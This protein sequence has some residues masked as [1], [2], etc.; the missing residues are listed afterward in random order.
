MDFLTSLEQMPFSVWVREGGSIWGYPTI[1]CL[2]TMGMATVAGIAAFISMRLLGIAPTLPIKPMERLYPIMWAGF[3]LNA[4]TG[5]ML[6][7]ADATTKLTN[8]DFYVKMG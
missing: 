8:W 2:H 6:L 7:I 4:I 5:T 1:L 3:W